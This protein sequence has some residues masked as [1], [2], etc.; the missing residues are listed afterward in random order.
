MQPSFLPNL[1]SCFHFVSIL[2]ITGFFIFVN[3]NKRGFMKV[4]AGRYI[5]CSTGYKAYIPNPLPPTINWDLNLVNALSEADMLL[6]RLAGEGGKLPNPHILIRPFIAREAV[7]SSRIE[8]TQ[9]TLGDILA[10]HAGATVEISAGDLREVNNYIKALQYGIERL[11]GLP[12]SLRLLQEIHAKLMTNVRG[13][14]ATP[15]EFR[16][17]QNWIGVAGCTLATA[18]YVPPCPD[19]LMDCLDAFE[20][21]LN[22]RSLPPLIQIALAHYQFEAIHPF[23][24]G[25]GRVGR[26][27]VTLFLVERGILPTPLLY[28]SAFFEATRT[29]YYDLLSAVTKKGAWSD[30]LNYF[31]NGVARQS[32]DALSRASRINILLDTWRKETAGLSTS[33]PNKLIDNLAMNPFMTVKQTA[34]TMKTSYTTIQRAVEKLEALKIVR[35]ISGGKRNRVYCAEALLKILEEP[36]RIFAQ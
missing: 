11:K 6:G 36:A 31:L 25:N 18:A 12:L 10:D 23:L 34:E 20:K 15:G 22:D 28:L 3:A 33:L 16:K 4:P 13:H 21:F 2:K 1:L 30:W 35:E 29:E 9:V 19:H 8:G 26:L 17:S 24:D 27:L 32:E 7:L 5:N 14:N